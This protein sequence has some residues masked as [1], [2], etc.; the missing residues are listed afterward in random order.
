MYF[1]VWLLSMCNHFFLFP[2]SR[3]QSLSQHPLLKM[4]ML[5]KPL[6]LSIYNLLN[7]KYPNKYIRPQQIYVGVEYLVVT[8]SI[9]LYVFMQVLLEKSGTK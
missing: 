3:N 6:N 2:P 7:L 1:H 4:C 9:V 5:Y 8:E